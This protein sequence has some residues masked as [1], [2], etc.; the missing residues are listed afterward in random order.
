MP[1]VAIIR[2]NV[3]PSGLCVIS[4]SRVRRE[5]ALVDLILSQ[6]VD[7]I[8][9]WSLIAACSTAVWGPIVDLAAGK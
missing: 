5:V 8:P 2:L 9:W 1:M 7:V 4:F 3:L 6:N